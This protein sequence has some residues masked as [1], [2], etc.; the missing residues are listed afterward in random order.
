MSQGIQK[1]WVARLLGG[2][3]LFLF[4]SFLYELKKS[5]NWKKLTRKKQI[6]TL[7]AGIIAPTA[8]IGNSPKRC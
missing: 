1:R 4:L 5:W 3:L 2:C 7:F 8:E 6:E